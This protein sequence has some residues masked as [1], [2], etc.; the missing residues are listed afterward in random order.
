MDDINVN[1]LT[2]RPFWETL[3]YE[4]DIKK[5]NIF[6]FLFAF[7]YQYGTFDGEFKTR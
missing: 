5:W 4:A 7:L 1:E 6:F 3:V 2:L